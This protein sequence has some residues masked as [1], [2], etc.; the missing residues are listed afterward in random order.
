MA[1]PQK[2]KGAANMG[3]LFPNI[4]PDNQ[5]HNTSSD[6][7]PR[8]GFHYELYR[9]ARPDLVA[10]NRFL[11]V[12]ASHQGPTSTP[13]TRQLT[14]SFLDVDNNPMQTALISVPSPDAVFRAEGSYEAVQCHG[15]W[16]WPQYL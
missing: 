1:R 5:Q 7:Q 14:A 11:W 6:N 8:D 2:E 9:N 12:F 13:Q 3:I 10:D 15:I 4:T 16:V